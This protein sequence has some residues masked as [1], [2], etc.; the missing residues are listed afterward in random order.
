[1]IVLTICTVLFAGFSCLGGHYTNWVTQRTTS[2]NVQF[3]VDVKQRFDFQ[4]NISFTKA[5]RDQQSTPKWQKDMV[6]CFMSMDTDE[7]QDMQVSAILKSKMNDVKTNPTAKN[8]E[9]FKNWTQ[10][11]Q[12]LPVEKKKG[13]CFQLRN[14]GGL[15]EKQQIRLNNWKTKSHGEMEKFVRREID[16][17][18]YWMH[19]IG[20]LLT[21]FSCSV[22]AFGAV[23]SLKKIGQ[24][25]CTVE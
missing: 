22:A 14:C 5:M 3:D 19:L 1:M 6:S 9:A 2:K 15:W 16:V 20:W 12:Y 4:K 23:A 10:Y 8:I 21:G 13:T 24:D 17:I 25:L 7:M 11:E 18:D